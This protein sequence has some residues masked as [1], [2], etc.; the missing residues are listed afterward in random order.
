MSKFIQTNT[1]KDRIQCPKCSTILFK[2]RKKPQDVVCPDC[3][4][5]GSF[6]YID[7]ETE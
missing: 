3:G 1:V 6:H 7:K 4:W 2:I 5:D